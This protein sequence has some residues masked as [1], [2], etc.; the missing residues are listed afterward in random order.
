MRSSEVS[1]PTSER[2]HDKVMEYVPRRDTR[3]RVED[4]VARGPLSAFEEYRIVEQHHKGWTEGLAAVGW[5][6]IMRTGPMP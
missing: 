2:V 4:H 1:S 3:H 6:L 5:N